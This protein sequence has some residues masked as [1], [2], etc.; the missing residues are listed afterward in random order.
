MAVEAFL[1][2]KTLTTELGEQARLAPRICH[3]VAL[4]YVVPKPHPRVWRKEVVFSDDV[5]PPT[6]R[7]G[8]SR[9]PSP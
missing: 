1:K 2:G 5:G 6:S 9:N 8:V 4:L 3:L 7:A